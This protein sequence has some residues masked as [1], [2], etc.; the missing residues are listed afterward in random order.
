M[1]M[2]SWVKEREPNIMVFMV[3]RPGRWLAGFL[4][5]MGCMVRHKWDKGLGLWVNTLILVR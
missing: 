5:N 3:T 1:F 4:K 2:V